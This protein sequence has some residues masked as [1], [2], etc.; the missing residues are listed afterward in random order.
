V[1]PAIWFCLLVLTTA[2]LSA[3]PPAWAATPQTVLRSVHPPCATCIVVSVTPEQVVVLPPELHGLEIL[4]AVAATDSDMGEI[5]GLLDTIVRRGGHPG[6]LLR[7]LPPEASLSNLSLVPTI[8]LDVRASSLPLETL[9]FELRKHL[10]ALRAAARGPLKLGVEPPEVLAGA[11][12][13]Q[14]AA[15]YWDVL[16][17]ESDSGAP[18]RWVRGGDLADAGRA[19]A[20]TRTAQA[21][22]WLV[23]APEDADTGRRILSDLASAARFLSAGLVHAGDDVRI[24]CGDVQNADV[25]LNPASLDRVALLEACDERSRVTVEPATP[26]ERVQLSSGEAIVRVAEAAADRFATDARVAAPRRLTVEEI[27]ARHQAAA[28]HQAAFVHTLISTGT[29]TVTFEAPGFPAPV[30][31]SSE[32]TIYRD[33]VRTELEQRAL[34]VNG[35]AFRQRGIPRLPIIEPER[36]AAPPLVITLGDKY[37]YRLAGE[38]TVGGIRAY[39]VTFDPRSARESLFHGRAWIAAD[40]FGLVRVEAAQTGLRGPVVSSEQIDEFRRT[41]GGAWVLARSDVRQLYQGA[42]Y[43]TPIHRVLNLTVHDVNAADFDAR[44]HAAYASEHTILR[45]TPAGYRYLEGEARRA[46]SAAVATGPAPGFPQKPLS[47]TPAAPTMDDGARAGSRVR[48]LA[49]GVIVDPNISQPLPFAGLSYLDFNLFGTGAQFNGFFGGTYGQMAFSVPS[50]GGTGWQVAGQAFG[51]ASSYNDRVFVS[52][53]EQYDRNVR[54]RPAFASVWLLRPLTPRL[55]VRAGYELDYTHFARSGATAPDFEAPADQVAHGLRLALEGQ[56]GG[57]DS[58]LWWSASRRAGWRAWGRHDSGD[59]LPRHADFQRYGW[60]VARSVIVS[61]RLV[62]RGE[63]SI[64]GGHDLDRFSEYA[65]GTFENRLRG[66]PSALIRYDRG[67]AVRTALAWSAGRLI[68]LDGFADMAFVRDS[69]FGRGVSR[70]TGIGAAVEAP[71]PFGTLVAAEWG[72]GIQGVNAD[73]RRGTHV[74]RITGYK[75]F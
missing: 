39:V 60:S 56:R 27:V 18:G 74:V 25:Y 3:G 36:V 52:G 14:M 45:D 53:R 6:I 61:P 11:L 1:R 65:F 7:G 5:P 48:T 31:V 28:V 68:R 71:A 59:Y 32:T 41:S 55:A 46:A 62:G 19:L 64:M 34:T 67:A 63:V 58:T 72:Y 26:I 9:V 66:Y 13:E 43:R 44:R 22:R 73:G 69:G 4:V 10:T 49:F 16:V 15:G 50:V 54:Q 24:A 29:L 38:E 37:R 23:R 30:T 42:A 21:E 35:I 57:W 70:F 2:A 17:S 75:V 47:A 40:D 33:A 12:Q 8:I 20:M 51:I